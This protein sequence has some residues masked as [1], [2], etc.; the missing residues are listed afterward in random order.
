[1]RYRRLAELGLLTALAVIFGWIEH[2][3]PLVPSVPGIKLGLGNIVI[4]LALYRFGRR[5]AALLS[6]AKVL[7][8]AL[9]FGGFSGILYSASGAILSL[10]VMIIMYKRKAFSP[11]GVSAAGGAAHITAQVLTAILLTSTTQIWRIL[12]VLLA[13]GTLT[14]ALNGLLTLALLGKLEK[15][16]TALTE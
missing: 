4:M 16:G 6:A 13:V 10:A 15:I 12:T 9:I 1:M 5:E 8:C 11:I 2:L 14:G 3:L 7:L